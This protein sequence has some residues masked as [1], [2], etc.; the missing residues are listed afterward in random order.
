VLGAPFTVAVNISPRQF[1]RGDLVSTVRRALDQSGL[2][3]AQLEL[4]I[5]EGVLMDE[6][7]SVAEALSELHELGVS[8]AIDDF[9]TGYSSLGYLKRYPIS[10]LKIDQSFVRDVP[11]DTGDVA[12][13]VAIISMGHSLGI[14]V[15]AEGIETEEQLTFLVA[16]HC[17]RGQG[18]YIGRPMAF[19][20]LLTWLPDDSRRNSG[21]APAT[22]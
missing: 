10:T 20:D 2:P 11:G 15:V 21:A 19:D 12:V 16:N 18:F 9:G 22:N 6:H 4:E 3:P 13:V 14:R 17:D 8:I 7:S 1:M 5:T